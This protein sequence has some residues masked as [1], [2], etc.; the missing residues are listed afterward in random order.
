MKKLIL[1]NKLEEL[2][3]SIH[4]FY[5]NKG[6]KRFAHYRETIHGFDTTLYKFN[7]IFDV[8]WIASEYSALEKVFKSFKYL[9]LDLSDFIANENTDRVTQN[10]A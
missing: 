2:A 5:F 3:N 6:H 4:N 9:H 1:K 7:Y 8:R 10:K